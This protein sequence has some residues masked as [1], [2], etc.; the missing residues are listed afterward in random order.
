MAV[1]VDTNVLVRSLEAD[2]QQRSGCRQAL[3]RAKSGRGD[4]FLCA[5][6]MIEFWAVATRPIQSNG[7]GFSPAV[8]RA[9]LDDLGE[10]LPTLPEPP[11]MAQRWLKLATDFGVSGKTTHDTRLVALMDAFG[12]GTILTLNDADFRRYGHLKIISPQDF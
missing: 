4:V 2:S 3:A 9:A 11:D 10:I 8:A 7:L 1:L 6:V 12:V 5:Q